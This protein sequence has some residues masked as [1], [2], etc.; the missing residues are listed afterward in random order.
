MRK[1]VPIQ[2]TDFRD[3]MIV[4]TLQKLRYLIAKS[5]VIDEQATEVR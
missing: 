5:L 3:G 1:W 2:A 4:V